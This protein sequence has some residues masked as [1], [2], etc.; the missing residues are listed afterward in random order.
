MGGQKQRKDE[1][2]LSGGSSN[3]FQILGDITEVQPQEGEIGG[4]SMES[5]MVDADKSEASSI[6]MEAEEA[7]DM[8]LGELD[9]DA[10]EAECRKDG[11]GYV[12]REQIEILHKRFCGLKV[13][14]DK[15][16]I[17]EGTKGSKR[18]TLE[19]DQK[20]GGSRTS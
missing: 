16:L 12:P 9:L 3:P 20:R 5:E 14:K 8:D 17:S 15:G 11:S 18:K 1:V 10:L 13:H 2:G 4:R 19:E 7:E 6:S